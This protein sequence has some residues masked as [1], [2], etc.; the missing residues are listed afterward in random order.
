MTEEEFLKR[1]QRQPDGAWACVK[2]LKIAGPNEPVTIGQGTRFGP[3]ALFMGLDL[4]KELDQ[5]AAKQRVASKLS[6][7][8]FAGAGAALK[9]AAVA[10]G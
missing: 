6:G 1:F 7:G 3:G 9:P 5:M 4:A 8:S 2:A 10:A